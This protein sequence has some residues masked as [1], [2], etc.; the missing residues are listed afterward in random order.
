MAIKTK[1]EILASIKERFAEDSSD[2]TISFIEDVSDTLSDYETRA[3]GDGTDW[4]AEAKRIDNEWREK[5]KARFFSAPKEEP[6]IDDS[7]F[8]E[9]KQ[10]KFED[11]FKE[12]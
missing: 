5:Y 6:D 8:D 9:P 7:E 12:G 11:L 1:D 3:N 4:K 10:L 2:E